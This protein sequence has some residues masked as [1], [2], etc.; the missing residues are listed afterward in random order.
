MADAEPPPQPAELE[1][2]GDSG[3]AALVIM[4]GFL[5]RPADAGRLRHDLGH[6]DPASAE[7]LVRLAKR[8][9][10]RAHRPGELGRSRQHAASRDRLNGPAPLDTAMTQLAPAA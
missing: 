3:L 1:R 4:F 6:G 5:R 7:D 8:E 9:K 10:V 2:G